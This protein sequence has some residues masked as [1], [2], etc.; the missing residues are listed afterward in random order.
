MR[1]EPS[2]VELSPEKYPAL[3]A[4]HL[5][6]WNRDHHGTDLYAEPVDIKQTINIQ[7]AVASHLRGFKV[8]RIEECTVYSVWKKLVQ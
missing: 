7:M 4:K 3:S 1:F 6:R 8:V 5:H 2:H